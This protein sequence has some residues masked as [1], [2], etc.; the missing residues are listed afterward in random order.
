[1]FR[2]I[3]EKTQGKLICKICRYVEYNLPKHHGKTLRWFISGNFDKIEYLKC[4]N[5]DYTQPI[6]SHCNIQMN[7][8]EGDYFDLPDFTK[9]DYENMKK[10]YE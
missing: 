10:E 4:E 5:C 9:K 3:D 6:A 2:G 7:Y 1:M 8:S